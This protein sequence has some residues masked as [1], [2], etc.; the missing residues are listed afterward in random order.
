[1][2]TNIFSKIWPLATVRTK[3]SVVKK[4]NV[5]EEITHLY[6]L[7]FIHLFDRT[8]LPFKNTVSKRF[9]AYDLLGSN[10]R[11]LQNLTTLGGSDRQTHV[12]FYMI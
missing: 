3:K 6:N 4:S 7:Y 11:Q 12:E 10:S 9:C 5:E 1:M 8:K 2:S